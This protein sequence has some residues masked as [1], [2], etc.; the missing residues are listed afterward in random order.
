L[1]NRSIAEVRLFPEETP[2]VATTEEL[3]NPI[4]TRPILGINV[5]VSSYEQL[6]Q[7]SFLWGRERQSRAIFFANV[8]MIMEAHDDPAFFRLINRADMVNPDGMPLVWALHALGEKNAQRVCGF[9]A[10]MATL[11]AAEKAGVPVGF[12]GN[13]PAALDALVRKVR[14]LHPNLKIGFL[15]CDSTYVGSPPYRVLTPEEDAALVER[16]AAS[17]VSVLFVGLGCPKQENWIMG[18]VGKV[19]TAMFGVGAVFDYLA[20]RKAQAPRWMM[21]SGLEWIFRFATEPRR[22][23]M[24]YLKHNPRFV[25]LFL[26]QL[27]TGRG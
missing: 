10:T 12:Y 27:V 11:D 22:L 26:W 7:R 20:G 19:P 2:S 23:A 25:F 4:A 21:N 24:R 9:D 15:E 17:G 13:T 8:H 16:I 14:S 3:Q 18:H 6:I 5:A 1:D